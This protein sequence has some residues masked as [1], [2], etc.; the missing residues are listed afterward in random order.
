[1]TDMIK[2][3]NPAAPLNTEEAALAA[4]KVSAVGMVIGAIHTA[5]GG[6]YAS[7]PAAQ[8]AA[9]RIVQDLTGQAPDPAAMASQAQMGL[10][11]SGVFVV[12]Q[13]GL[14]FLQSRKPNMIL[15][16]MFLILCVWA[17]GSS[18]LALAVPAF[19]GSQPM[20]LTAFSIIA[21]IVAIITHIASI[22]GVSALDKIRTRA[23]QEY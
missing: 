4:A 16:I 17:L 8:E 19:G 2:A 9:A 14:A 13:L 10:I 7:T 21:M 23:A 6:W 20:W 5:V 1:M 12:L 3:M 18:A 22:R 11:I 15:P